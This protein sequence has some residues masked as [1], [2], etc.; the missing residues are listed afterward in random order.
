MASSQWQAA[1]QR[2]K[3]A[4]DLHKGHY[5]N[6]NKKQLFL[7]SKGGGADIYSF[8]TFPYNIFRIGTVKNPF[9]DTSARTTGP[10][11]PY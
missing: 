10:N 9:W 11:Y 2:L 7:D 4:Y 5:T 6:L 8:P 3:E 1:V